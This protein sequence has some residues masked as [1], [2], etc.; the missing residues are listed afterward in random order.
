MSRQDGQAAY[1]RVKEPAA[2]VRAVRYS[3]MA[4]RSVP[5][6]PVATVAWA[7][8]GRAVAT[9][10]CFVTGCSWFGLLL[11]LLAYCAAVPPT[12]LPRLW[13]VTAAVCGLCA[14]L[15]YGVGA[16]AGLLARTLWA[17]RP[18]AAL[19]AVLLAAHRVGLPARP[20]RRP[21]AA[22]R[23]WARRA[24]WLALAALTVIL[25][26]LSA[27]V[28]AI[29]EAR[30]ARS[31]DAN[32]VSTR[33]LSTLLLAGTLAVTLL[34]IARSLRWF[35]RWLARLAPSAV[36]FPAARLAAG[37]VTIALVLVG[38]DQIVGPQVV[39]YLTRV[40]DAANAGT[41]AGAVPPRSP[42][43]SGSPA[44]LA[45]WASLGMEGR[46][47]VAAGPDAARIE[48]VTGEPARMPIRVF[49]GT[50]TARSVA[51]RVAL[52]VRELERTGAFRQS[53]VAIV[54][55]T[56]T[57]WVDPELTNTVEYLFGG[58]TAEV[59]VQ[60]SNLPSW[61]SFVTDRE[62]AVAVERALVQAVRAR[63]M[64]MTPQH[65]PMLV[66]LGE[67][68]GAYSG[69]NA[70]DSLAQLTSKVDAAVFAGS[71]YSSRISRHLAVKTAAGVGLPAGV[72]YVTGSDH[73]PAGSARV[74]FVQHESDPILRWTPELIWSRPAWTQ[75]AR[76][77]P[78]HL[79]WLP[80]ITFL[81]ISA[82]LI[83][84]RAVGAG[85]G[86]VYGIEMVDAV[87]AAT[88]PPHWSAVRAAAVRRA[89]Q[90]DTDRSRPISRK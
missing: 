30:L 1:H 22:Q 20:G 89:M 35:S 4:R 75:T 70:F 84:S 41:P 28:G 42:M 87:A 9:A 21:A 69:Q 36:P 79:R 13:F 66:V 57:G 38:G 24:P 16:A 77:T 63:I 18:A 46:R 82:D 3:A 50:E 49:T 58:D 55:T 74:V 7:V 67:S 14:M 59:A 51:A 78:T 40:A 11:A 65:R 6:S 26:P 90:Q 2:D 47:F 56:G 71:P 61:L 73:P 29:D 52:A 8:A 44:S 43:R 17:H 64:A 19:D 48:A 53:V 54:G 76:L 27:W 85:E 39:G 86:H 34:M 12:M 15:A 68:L 83:R 23:Q 25:V 37:T 45:R 88:N 33:P 10:R 32:P 80:G 31:L 60:Y 62:D 5:G 81:E 72:E